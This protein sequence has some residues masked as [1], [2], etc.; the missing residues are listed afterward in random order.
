MWEICSVLQDL[1]NELILVHHTNSYISSFCSFKE[2]LSQISCTFIL[3][4][5]IASAVMSVT[6]AEVS[7]EK[8]HIM[9]EA[10]VG[11]ANV[12]LLDWDPEA[13]S[14]GNPVFDLEVRYL[15]RELWLP[16]LLAL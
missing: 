16:I 15:S 8:A 4:D 6:S 12:D 9:D 14:Y 3:K 1:Q 10:R 11:T 2:R 5:K 7:K 13:A